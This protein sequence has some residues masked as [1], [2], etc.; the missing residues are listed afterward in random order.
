MTDMTDKASAWLKFQKALTPDRPFFI[1]FAPG[2]THAPHHVAKEWID[3][4]RASSTRAGT[5]CGRRPWRVRSSSASCRPVTKL[6]PKPEAIKDWATLSADEKK[7]FTRQMEIYAGFA[8][9]TDTEIG[10]LIDA[11]RETGQLDNTLVI[12]ILGDNGT[13]A[14][15]GMSGMYN[16]YTYFNGGVESVADILK[17][18]DQLGGPMSYGHMSA[19]WAVAGDTPFS[20][21]KQV[22][23]DYGGNQTGVIIRWPDRVKAKGEIRS[24][25]HHVID[26]APTVLEAAGLPEAEGR[27]RHPPA[28]DRRGQL[29]LHLRRRQGAGPPPGPVLRDVRQPRPLRRRLVR[30]DHPQ[31][32]VGAEA[33]R[34]A[35]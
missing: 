35:D 25:F 5:R 13:S 20:W 14:E 7:L 15:G 22:G 11:V 1:Y 21:A 24:Q 28:A 34:R 6:A 29:R 3:S 12:Y 16:E 31:G 10:R 32:A 27:Q 23:S 8:E 9:F 26:V 2:A 19:G 33:A 4:T 17:H 18:Y 30:A